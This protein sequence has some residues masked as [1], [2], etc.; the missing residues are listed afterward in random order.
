[1]K[2]LKILAVLVAPL[3][4]LAAHAAG[5]HDA[6]GCNG[7][8]SIHNAKGEFIFEVAANKK[9]TNPKTNQPV[10]G[11]SALCLGCHQTKDKG[12]QDIAPISG[13]ISHPFSLTEVNAKIAKVPAEG[14]RQGKFECTGCH[15]P[16]PSN[17]NY[18]YL[19]VDTGA[20][21]GS[22]DKFCAACH[23]SKADSTASQNVAFFSSMDERA[24][25]VQ[26]VHAAPAA[27]APAKKK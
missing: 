7:C 26:A 2:M 9:A 21:G 24:P 10:G 27:P 18:K 12:G 8:H 17:P 3:L 14:L 11:V 1:M 23:S 22:M 16:H 15:D 6:V 13:H 5:G 25:R 19:R 20:K 4:P